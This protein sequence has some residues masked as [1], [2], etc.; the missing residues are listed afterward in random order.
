MLAVVAATAL[1]A[2]GT[3]PAAPG[4]TA[5]V[6]A[7]PAD[8]ARSETTHAVRVS[9]P[10]SAGSDG[11]QWNDV[12]VRY[13]G[14]PRA[15]ADEVTADTVRAGVDRGDD[16]PGTRVDANATVVGALSRER[17][18]VLRVS[19]AGE[20]G[21][22]AGDEVVVV[23]RPVENPPRD[24]NATV[25]VT[26]NSQGTGDAAT[27]TVTYAYSDARIAFPNQTTNGRW[28]R[29]PSATVSQ[30]G[31]VAVA[32][33]R[34]ATPDAVRGTSTYLPPGRHE[35]VTVRLDDPLAGDARLYAH[36]HHDTDGDRRF[37]FASSGG[38]VDGMYRNRNGRIIAGDAATVAVGEPSPTAATATS[39]EADTPTAADA[40]T[41]AATVD[42]RASDTTRSTSATTTTGTVVTRTPTD[43]TGPGFGV[44]VALL[45]AATM[46]LLLCRR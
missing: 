19:L 30:G 40:T 18:H 3:G 4:S 41:D 33:E 22:R 15:D 14:E 5:S 9:L 25:E 34:G 17:G 1:A 35:N 46:A 44:R 21:L 23:F 27:G 42:T 7:T 29:V 37:E 20:T 10:A 24:G 32:D 12:V 2:A 31:F 6:N 28:V 36:V 38:E 39:R 43:A 13:R 8:P 45:A 11:Q 26:V 16:D